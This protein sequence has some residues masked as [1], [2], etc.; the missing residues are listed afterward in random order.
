M[1]TEDT[2]DPV[3]TLQFA[4][5]G[6]ALPIMGEP[7]EIGRVLIVKGTHVIARGFEPNEVGIANLRMIAEAIMRKFGYD[8]IRVEGEI[9]TTGANK[10]HRPR[11]FRFSRGRRLDAWPGPEPGESD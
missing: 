1:V 10:G 4:V 9:R 3:V 11:P 6:G 7:E 8:E 2:S 5:P